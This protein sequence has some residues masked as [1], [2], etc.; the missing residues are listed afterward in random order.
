MK[1]KAKTYST[2]DVVKYIDCYLDSTYRSEN[3]KNVYS[4]I[5]LTSYCQRSVKY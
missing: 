2:F 5:I 1:L 3:G 4:L